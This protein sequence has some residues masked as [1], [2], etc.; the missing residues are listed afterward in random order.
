MPSLNHH[1]QYERVGSRKRPKYWRCIH[2]D[3]SHYINPILVQGKRA[4]C[5]IKGCTETFLMDTGALQRKRPLCLLHRNTQEGRT[6]QK[7]T[8]ILDELLGEPEV[9]PVSE[10]KERYKEGTGQ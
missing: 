10:F 8:S 3:C 7:I 1:H 6:A 2:P 9:P 5:P 4:G